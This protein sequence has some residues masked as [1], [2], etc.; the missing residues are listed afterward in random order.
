[1]IGLFKIRAVFKTA[2]ILSIFISSSL[3]AGFIV[4]T[5]LKI[6]DKTKAKMKEMGDEL[7]SKTG[8][9]T[10]IVAKNSL[11]KSR[12]LELKSS[13]LKELKAPYVLWMFA[14]NYRDEDSN[15]TG[16]LNV[17]L[18]SDDLKGKFDESSMFS[19]FGGSF[20]KLIVIQKSKS[21]PTGAAFLNGYADLTDMLAS[22]YG[23]KLDSSIGN[24]TKTTM[25]I[26]R[27]FFYAVFL[28]F[29]L[30]YIKNK[31]LKKGN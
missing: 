13:Y 19:P 15:R 12:F 16:K 29:F 7:F 14:K 26:I 10:A 8:I 1:L 21:D 24:E 20:T 5:D 11:N 23:I 30:W 18:S 22:S 17:L 2:L 27:V 4:D 31:I 9:S 3:I 28:F 25:D 6:N